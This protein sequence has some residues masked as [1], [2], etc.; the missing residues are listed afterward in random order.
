MKFATPGQASRPRAVVTSTGPPPRFCPWQDQPAAIP[1]QWL[2]GARPGRCPTL[3][4]PLRCRRVQHLGDVVWWKAVLALVV[5]IS[6]NHRRQLRQR[7]LQRDP[8]RRT[9][10]ASAHATGRL[11]SGL[12]AT[13][14]RAAFL[15]SA[16]ARS[17]GSY[18]R[19]PPPG[20]WSSSALSLSPAHGSAPAANVRTTSSASA[21]S[22]CSCS[23]ASSRY[24]APRLWVGDWVGWVGL[25][26]AVAGDSISTAVLVVN[27]LRDVP[28]DTESGKMTAV[29]LGDTSTGILFGV[30]VFV[31]AVISVVLITARTWALL[32]LAALPLMWAA[33]TGPTR[34]YRSPADPFDR[35]HRPG[36][37]RGGRSSPP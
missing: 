32:S 36:D 23:S 22:P 16:S 17:A 35:R 25:A 31:P 11:R 33:S 26:C 27:N 28:T 29:R 3:S 2:R 13:V 1:K 18:S 5:T 10:T 9:T 19:S 4:R 37:A 8:R 24:S 14:K 21:R 20:G 30:R 7:L 6:S 12:P 34:H 15:A